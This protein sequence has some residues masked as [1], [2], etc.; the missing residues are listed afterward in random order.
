M[1]SGAETHAGSRHGS[2]FVISAFDI[3]KTTHSLSTAD[4]K[5]AGKGY[6]CFTDEVGMALTFLPYCALMGRIN[7]IKDFVLCSTKMG[8]LYVD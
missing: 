1:D 3:A 5:A 2:C 7:D 8:M 6:I 4:K